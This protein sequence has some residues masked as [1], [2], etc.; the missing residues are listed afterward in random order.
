MKPQVSV[1]LPTYNR[2]NMLTQALESVLEQSFKDYELIII[3][4]GSTDHTDQV[5]A[6]YPQKAFRVIAQSN[7]GVSAARNRGIQAA[8]ANLIAFIDSDD[9]WY[10]DKLALQVEFFKAHPDILICQTEE[11]WIRNNQRVNPCKH[12][13]KLRGMLFEPSL[14][15]CLVSPSA[16]MMCRSLFE[17]VG[18]FDQNLPACEDYD[19]WL[20][21]SHRYPIELI[22]KALVIKRGGH[23]DQLS[24][25][26]ALDCFRIASIKKLLESGQLS[27]KHTV[28]ALKTI[29]KKCSIYANGCRK[30]GRL[31]DA[32]Y[33]DTLVENIN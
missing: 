20:R 10:A 31:K 3:D 11:I 23:A 9:L 25:M 2:A 1:I 7:Q 6:A 19:L 12:H 24:R 22:D 33:Y 4:D 26:P 14:D 8:K 18:F 29:K 13:R 27:K 28:A 5:L 15:L 30:R 17:C 21:V 32:H 16:V